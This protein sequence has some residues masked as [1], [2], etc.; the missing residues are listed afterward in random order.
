MPFVLKNCRLGRL[1]PPQY[2]PASLKKSPGPTRLSPPRLPLLQGFSPPPVETSQPPPLPTR[3]PLVALL[4]TRSSHSRTNASS[5]GHV[6]YLN[7]TRIRVQGQGHG[8]IETIQSVH[9][10]LFKRMLKAFKCDSVAL[11]NPLLTPLLPFP[12]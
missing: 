5:P 7:R 12:R 1:P 9:Y 8:A 6:T 11:S 10:V 3:P 4:K 2:I